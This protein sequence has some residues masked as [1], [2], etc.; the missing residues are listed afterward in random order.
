MDKYKNKKL[1]NKIKQNILIFCVA[2][3]SCNDSFNAIRHTSNTWLSNFFNLTIMFPFIYYFFPLIPFLVETA[4]F[5]FLIS[6]VSK[7]LQRGSY[8]V[9]SPASLIHRYLLFSETRNTFSLPKCV[10]SWLNIPFYLSIKEAFFH[11]WWKS[12]L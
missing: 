7:S 2:S 4:V 1:L 9:S 8:L 10:P 12:G 5:L 11:L 6:G 3:F